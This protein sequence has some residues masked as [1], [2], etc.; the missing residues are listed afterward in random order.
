M[1]I[2]M[3]GTRGVPAAYGGFETAIE[4]IGQRLVARG[5]EVTVYC[6]VGKN[7]EKPATH[8]GMK[9][10]Y[11]PAM[12]KKTLETLSHTALSALHMMGTKGHDAAFVFNA[13]NAPFVPMIKARRTP[14]AVHVDGLEWKRGKWGKWGKRYYRMAEEF[15]VR[16]GD[17]LISDAQGIA[18]Y[19]EAEFGVPTELLTY[20]ANR[21]TDVATDKLAKHGLEAG[22]FHVA[23]AR[24]EPENHVDVIVEGYT[25]SKAQYPLVVVGSAPYAEE[26]TDRIAK[27]AAADP[28]IKMLG[29]VWDQD[30]LNQLYAHA[31]TYIHGHSVGGTN[32]SLLRAMGAGTAVIAFDVNFNREVAG[33]EGMFFSEATQLAPHLHEIEAD[34]W[35]YLAIGQAM[36]DRAIKN[37]NWDDVTL[38]YEALAIKL[39]AGDSIHGIAKGRRR[40]KGWQT[41]ADAL[42]PAKSS[43]STR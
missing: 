15:A 19:Y 25:A 22:K 40:K 31:R 26:Y 24:F 9:L 29:G 36:Q 28:R 33:P 8:L 30:E 5:H 1:R 6:R 7:G 27:M 17:A 37:Y 10:V 34:T 20:G 43:A 18:D 11:L 2:A 32:P 12:K 42:L 35:R 4:E 39:A 3:V 16:T 13:A 23:V 38:G 41:T 21:L 14:V